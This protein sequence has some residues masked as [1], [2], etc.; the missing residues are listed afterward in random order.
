MSQSIKYIKDYYHVNDYKYSYIITFEDNTP[1][2]LLKILS[3]Y[4][5]TDEFYDTKTSSIMN[6]YYNISLK[7]LKHIINE[8]NSSPSTFKLYINFRNDMVWYSTYEPTTEFEKKVTTSTHST[9]CTS[10]VY[11]KNEHE[12]SNLWNNVII[13]I[14]PKDSV[15]S[16]NRKH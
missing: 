11:D 16:H 1:Y 4:L 8:Q 13:S 15:R 6:S 9:M 3:W 5:V 2:S 14:E 10:K 12:M 7:T